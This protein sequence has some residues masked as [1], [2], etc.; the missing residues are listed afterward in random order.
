[1]KDKDY[2]WLIALVIVIATTAFYQRTAPPESAASESRP[3]RLEVDSGE[4]S[5]VSELPVSVLHGPQDQQAV[6]KLSFEGHK[7]ARIKIK[8]RSDEAPGEWSLNIGD[9]RSNNGYSGDSGHQTHDSEIQIL[10]TTMSIWG[11]DV[12]VEKQGRDLKH[13]ND[14]V[15]PGQTVEFEISDQMVSWKSPQDTG[16]LR[17]H[18]LFALADQAE[19][20]GEVNREIFVGINQVV[21]GGRTG[22]GVESVEIEMLR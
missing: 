7:K 5:N 6:L 21:A 8:Y 16:N 1:M 9:S 12:M 22:W 2:L 20:E 10:G 15:R 17:S 13:V 18:F 11:S 19:L 4:V 3:F 14:F